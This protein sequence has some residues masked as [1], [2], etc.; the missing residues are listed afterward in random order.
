[1]HNNTHLYYQNICSIL[2]SF[3][4]SF[5]FLPLT[6]SIAQFIFEIRNFQSF[7]SHRDV[8]QVLF[9]HG[10]RGGWRIVQKAD[11]RRSNARVGG[12]KHFLS[13]RVGCQ[14]PGEYCEN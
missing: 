1:M 12:E 4:P 13:D 8:H 14:T 5:F 2:S 3:S 11:F 7:R 6:L 10:T 9:N